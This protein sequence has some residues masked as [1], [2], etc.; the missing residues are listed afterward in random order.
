MLNANFATTG[1]CFFSFLNEYNHYKFFII[2]TF[3]EFSELYIDLMNSNKSMTEYVFFN[4]TSVLQYTVLG[5][6]LVKFEYIF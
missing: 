6:F 4:I 2:Q 3:S 5:I 1:P